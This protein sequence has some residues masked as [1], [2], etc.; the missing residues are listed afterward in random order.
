M[1]KIVPDPPFTSLEDILVRISTHL[2]CA[3]S[4]AEQTAQLHPRPPEKGLT[5]TI[6]HEIE[7]AGLLLEPGLSRFQTRH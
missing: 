3:Q 2:D 6:P 5:L 4:V 1:L 7:R